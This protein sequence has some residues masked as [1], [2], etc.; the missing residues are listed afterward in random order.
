MFEQI[1]EMIAEQLGMDAAEIKPESLTLGFQS[2]AESLI[3]R[4]WLNPFPKIRTTERPD[5][6]T[7]FFDVG[8]RF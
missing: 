8:I 2:L 1:A 7:R 4:G 3:R 5:T 6:A